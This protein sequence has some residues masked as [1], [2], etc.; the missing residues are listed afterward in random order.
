MCV[1]VYIVDM[2]E[3]V[4]DETTSRPESVRTGVH[5]GSVNGGDPMVQPPYD[6]VDS[7]TAGHHRTAAVDDGPPGSPETVLEAPTADALRQAAGVDQRQQQR[8]RPRSTTRCRIIPIVVSGQSGARLGKLCYE[9][10]ET[11]ASRASDPWP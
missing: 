9:T 6:H 8:Q 2:D 3:T 1:G 11:D 5:P 10:A 4:K 7:V